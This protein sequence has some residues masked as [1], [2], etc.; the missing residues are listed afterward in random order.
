[1]R[2]LLPTQTPINRF[3][4]LL[5]VRRT[6]SIFRVVVSRRTRG[7]DALERH[8]FLDQSLNASANDCDHVAILHHFGFV[9]ESTVTG[10]DIGAAFLEFRGHRELEDAVELYVRLGQ[11]L[12]DLKQD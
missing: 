4:K 3:H 7:L 10:N 8:A 12:Q 5:R 1:M 9:A 11:D 2:T 6:R